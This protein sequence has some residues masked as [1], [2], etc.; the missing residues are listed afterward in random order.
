M[1][2]L[3]G[4]WWCLFLIN[5][6]KYNYNHSE[7]HDLRNPDII[8]PLKGAAAVNIYWFPIQDIN[9]LTRQ[10]NI[11]INLIFFFFKYD[12]F[13]I[14]RIKKIKKKWKKEKETA[15][16]KRYLLTLVSRSSSLFPKER[17]HLTLRF[18]ILKVD[19]LTP[20][21]NSYNISL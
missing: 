18:I 16:V 4:G 2:L 17:P 6:S 21:Y 5:K 8:Y 20:H 19:L 1:N 14:W 12:K 7:E 3:F 11:L 13:E 9:K 10:R 15:R